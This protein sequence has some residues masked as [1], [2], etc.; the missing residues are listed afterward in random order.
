MQR[1][2]FSVVVDAGEVALVH[3]DGSLARTLSPGRYNRR[4]G[5]TYVVVDMSERLTTLA[6]QEIPTAE[7]VAVKVGS[8]VRWKVTDPVAFTTRTR[9]AEDVL[10]LEAQVALRTVLAEL[11]LDKIAQAP[12]GDASLTDRVRDLVNSAVAELGISVVAVVARDVILPSEVRQANLDL[13]TARVRGLAQL[14]TARA[15]TATLRS[16]ANAARVLD[17]S[18]A[19]ERLRLV[20]SAPYGAQIRIEMPASGAGSDAGGSAPSGDAPAE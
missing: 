12:R 5:E 11:P 18:P 14:E 1:R 6:P 16:L 9:Q 20:Q 3:R 19:L 17:A 8:A 10:Y 2:L 7:G 15:E 4:R 13:V